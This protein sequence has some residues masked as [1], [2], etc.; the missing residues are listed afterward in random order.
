MDWSLSVLL[1][2]APKK[3]SMTKTQVMEEPILEDHGD[4]FKKK[5]KKKKLFNSKPSEAKLGNIFSI[6]FVSLPQYRADYI[7]ILGKAGCDKLQVLFCNF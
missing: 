2:G 5:K 3:A 7:I 4:R 1:Q 6:I